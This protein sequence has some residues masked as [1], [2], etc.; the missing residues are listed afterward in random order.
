MIEAAA[1]CIRH[2]AAMRPQM[3]KVIIQ[4]KMMTML[5]VRGISST[6]IVLLVLWNIF[7][8]VV[9]VLDILTDVDLNNGV[10]PGQSEIF[11]V[12][13]T[14]EIRLL[15]RMAFGSHVFSSGYSQSD[16]SHQSDIWKGLFSGLLLFVSFSSPR[17]YSLA[18]M[19]PSLWFILLFFLCCCLY[20]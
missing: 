7:V 17:S 5:N 9:R 14:A 3:G 20:L 15:Q 18:K 10:K 11:N 8:Q 1:A 6:C 13:E 4:H 19:R 2:S 16:W 12:A